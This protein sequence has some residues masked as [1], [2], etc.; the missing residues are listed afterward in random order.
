MRF[1]PRL[2]AS[3]G[4]G[5][6]SQ[7]RERDRAIDR[8]EQANRS[9]PEPPQFG[10]QLVAERHPRADEIFPGSDQR[11]QR[12]RLIA[13]GLQQPEAVPIGARQ[14]TQHEP[15]VLIGLPARSANPIT[16][17]LDLVRGQRQHP[18]PRFE[19]PVDQQPI[20]PLDRDHLDREA[21]Q[22][23]AQRAHA[24]LV[25]RERRRHQLLSGR[26]LDQH[27]VLL[28]APV[29][30]RAITHHLPPHTQTV[31]QRP[32]PE[33]PLRMLIDKA[34]DRGYVLSPLAAP[35]HRREGLVFHRPSVKGK[36]SR[37]S[38][39]GGRGN[40]SLPHQRSSATRA[41]SAQRGEVGVMP[42]MLVADSEQGSH[43]RSL[44][45]QRDRQAL[46]HHD[47]GHPGAA[48]ASM[49]EQACRRPSVRA[50]PWANASASVPDRT[51][52]PGGLRSPRAALG[53]ADEGERRIRHVLTP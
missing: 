48:A 21:H 27:V 32:D 4:A 51:F 10:A 44:A 52:P 37:P 12:L 24:I 40:P 33:V 28:R 9:R 43:D 46:P 6:A 42:E 23:R 45:S 31:R 39:G 34:L 19:Q 47:C 14:L 1:S 7:E 50:C 2:C 25:V 29:D 26:V 35:H 16:R 22:C 20:G 11:P 53:F 17:R 8:G 5:I 41:L 13:I 15:V 18:H 38:P 49:D 30:P 3:A 36:Q